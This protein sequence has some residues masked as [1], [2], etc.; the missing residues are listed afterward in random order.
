MS[1]NS[2][3]CP[4]VALSFLVACNTEDLPETVGCDSTSLCP[5]GQVCDLAIGQCIAEPPNRFVGKFACEVLGPGMS[6][7][8]LPGSEVIGRVEDDR[9]SLP[10]GGICRFR[11][12]GGIQFFDLSFQS[13]IAPESLALFLRAPDAASGGRIDLVQADAAFA[14]NSGMFWEPDLER[15]IAHAAG[16]YVHFIQPAAVGATVTGFIDVSVH[17]TIR[18]DGVVAVPC[19]RGGADCGRSPVDPTRT[20]CAEYTLDGVPKAMCVRDC[21]TDAD[22]SAVGGICI[23]ELCTAACGM[24][25][26]AICEPPLECVVPSGETNAGCF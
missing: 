17:P 16:G 23:Q 1:P 21:M 9:W 3:P 13:T 10:V 11:E 6:P 12:S 18:E 20:R 26:P 4:W 7:S 22:C 14:L 5:P 19:P 25:G 15:V 8:S 2:H 24:S